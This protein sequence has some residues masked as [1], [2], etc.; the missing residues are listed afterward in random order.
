MNVILRRP[1]WTDVNELNQLFD[2][3]VRDTFKKEKIDDETL[4]LH[5]IEEK[6]AF[7]LEDLES[8]GNERFFLVAVS[9]DRLVGTICISRSNPLIIEVA[10]QTLEDILEIGTV[11][12][13]PAYQAKGIGMK[14]LNAIYLV[15]LARGA[16]A[17]CLDSGYKSAQKI[18]TKKLGAPQYVDLNKWGEG[19]AHMVWHRLLDS[20]DIQI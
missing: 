16:S 1:K 15:L 7:L 5:E 8:G 13:H 4:M 3:V 10:G 12:V 20:V 17:F 14:L 2:C 6:Q 18:W 19:H 9:E 11:Y